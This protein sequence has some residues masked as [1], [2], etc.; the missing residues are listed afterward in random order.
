[1]LLEHVVPEV[2]QVLPPQHGWPAPPQAAQ[3]LFEQVTPA[4]VHD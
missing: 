2:V 1:V 3:A 4:A